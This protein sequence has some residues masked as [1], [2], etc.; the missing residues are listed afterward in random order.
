[1]ASSKTSPDKKYDFL[2]LFENQTVYYLV[3]L[4]SGA[5]K[6]SVVL[7]DDVE[8]IT[9]IT[10]SPDSK[11]VAFAVVNQKRY[12]KMAK[13]FIVDIYAGTHKKVDVD[14]K[15]MCGASCY[16]FIPFWS[17]DGSYVGII[18]GLAQEKPVISI[19]KLDGSSFKKISLPSNIMGESFVAPEVIWKK[20]ES[21]SVKI[22]KGK[23][24]EF[25][26]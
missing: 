1:M 17:P 3:D 22:S 24:Y 5:K 6:K 13:L 4:R 18:E 20:P 15:I 12:P 19:F 2:Y 21:I 8:G 14:S 7:Y 10:W 26:L 16:S 11:Y 23:H 9:D 25:H